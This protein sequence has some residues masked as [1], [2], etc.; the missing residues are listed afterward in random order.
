MARYGCGAPRTRDADAGRRGGLA[1]DLT[2]GTIFDLALRYVVRSPLLVS[3]SS[4]FS[5]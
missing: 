3:F 2:A 4:R 5:I 1:V